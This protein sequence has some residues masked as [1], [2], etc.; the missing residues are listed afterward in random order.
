MPPQLIFKIWRLLG[1]IPLKWL[2]ALGRAIG[3]FYIWFPNRERRITEI[4][5]R[6]CFPELADEELIQLRDEGIKQLGCT[7]MEM[8]AIWFVPTRKATGLIREISG[9]ELLEREEGQGLIVLLPHLGCW[10]IIGLEL[11][12]HEQVTSLYRPPRKGEYE[13][14]VKQARERSG[15]V[16]VPTDTSGVKRIYQALKLGGVTCILPDQ[17][18]KSDKGA[19]FAPFFGISALTMLLANRLVRKTGAKVI[20]AYAERLA[21]GRGYHIHYLPAP[22]AIADQNPVQAATALNQG[23]QS[24]VQSLPTQYQWSYKRF[25]I[26]PEG[27]QSPY[28]KR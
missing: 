18:P 11:P 6:L 20:F 25:H 17:Q 1:Y 26:Q 12:I 8:A 2:H 15:A 4:N 23:V 10:E 21:G 13:T 14:V 7:L 19:V 16:L 28:R 9:A 5:L 27:E 24:L 3:Y 22:D